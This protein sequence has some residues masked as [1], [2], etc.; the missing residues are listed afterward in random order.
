[1]DNKSDSIII[2][3]DT[4]KAVIKL[5]CLVDVI[6]FPRVAMVVTDINKQLPECVIFLLNY[7]NIN[8]IKPKKL[9]QTLDVDVSYSD[10][11]R[12]ILSF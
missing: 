1:M 8:V 9:Y 11:S 4:T 6:S 2:R 3:C 10:R 12:S 5:N 7:L